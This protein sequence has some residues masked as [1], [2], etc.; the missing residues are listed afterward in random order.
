MTRRIPGPVDPKAKRLKKEWRV[1][2]YIGRRAIAVLDV[3]QK[4]TRA[5]PD[6]VIVNCRWRLAEFRKVDES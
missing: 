4:T 2:Y 5:T 6:D 1:M 3:F